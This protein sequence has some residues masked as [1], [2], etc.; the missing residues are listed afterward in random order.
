VARD[1]PVRPV[2]TYSPHT[3]RRKPCTRCD[4]AR[5]GA[6]P[7]AARRSREH[8]TPSEVEHLIEVARK[9]GWASRSMLEKTTKID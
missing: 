7:Y 8:L 5:I 3:S 9:R 1:L 2:S 4:W 6:F